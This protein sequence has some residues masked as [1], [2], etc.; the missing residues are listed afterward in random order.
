MLINRRLLLYLKGL[1]SHPEFFILF[2]NPQADQHGRTT[3]PYL[4]HRECKASC[5]N[6]VSWLSSFNQ[7]LLLS[8][9]K[10]DTK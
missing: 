6:S 9:Q 7:A 1:N 4:R 3:S 10:L 8:R 5:D 2:F